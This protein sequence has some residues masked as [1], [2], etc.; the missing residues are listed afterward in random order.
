MRSVCER[1]RREHDNFAVTFKVYMGEIRRAVRLSL[2]QAGS[3]TSK[4]IIGRICRMT[5]QS[6]SGLR[7][8]EDATLEKMRA[9]D[10]QNPWDDLW[11]NPNPPRW[12][13][14]PE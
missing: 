8:N 1:E 12:I 9:R 5:A 6:P 3:K 14:I 10:P 2:M 11:S 4:G 13:E 7:G